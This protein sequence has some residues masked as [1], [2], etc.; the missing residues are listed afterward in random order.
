MP[1]AHSQSAAGASGSLE[2]TLSWEAV[3]PVS[4]RCC[5][6][7]LLLHMLVFLPW[8]PAGRLPGQTRAPG[9]QR[10]FQPV[11]GQRLT[12]PIRLVLPPPG[13]WDPVPPAAPAGSADQVHVDLATI[14]LSFADDTRGEFPEVVQAQHGVL[15]LLDNEDQSL[16][17]YVLEP[18]GWRAR[19][20][21]RDVS[22]YF[23]ILMSPPE[24]WRV[25]REAAER[26]GIDLGHYQACAL[27]EA[28]FQICLKKA[29]LARAAADPKASG[30][31]TS[32]RLGVSAGRPCGV[33]V[34]EVSFANR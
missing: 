14:R 5:A 10:N 18:P 25:F 26:D 7:S 13:H 29:I 30:H 11:A 15:A 22:G 34:L 23:G 21:V 28:S 12:I 9:R 2:R 33:E 8:I 16:A 19:E 3:K 4:W 32:A 17:R 1:S 27:F 24:K 20:S 6:G 31:V